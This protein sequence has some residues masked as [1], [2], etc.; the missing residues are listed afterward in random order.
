MNF[1]K[2]MI[3]V[4]GLMLTL[5]VFLAGC[6]SNPSAN[7]S[8]SNN[9]S[10]PSA[11]TKKEDSK[12]L[13]V[14]SNSLSDGRGDW[15]KEKA[16]AQ[17]FKLEFV[18]AGGGD[19]A[20]R[21]IAEKNNP[22]ADVVFGLSTVDY[23]GFKT[24]G[25]LEKFKPTWSDE[26]TAGLNDKED[27]YHSLVKQ[28]ILLIYNSKLYD[29]NTAPK[30][31]TDLW[32][33]SEF[34]NKYDAPSA[35]GGGTIRAVLAGI[36]VRYQDPNGEYGISKAGWDEIKNYLKNGYHA[37]QG[38]DFYANLA[39]GKSP[40]GPMWSSGIATREEKYG[41]KAGIVKPSIGVPFV[42]EQI[43]IVKGSKNLEAA[44]QFVNWFGSAE[45]QSEWSKKFTTMPANEK[46][47]ATASKDIKDLEAS[48]KVQNIDWAFVAKNMNKWV[49]KIQLELLP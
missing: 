9:P 7:T 18:E 45:V 31:W 36:L 4:T 16:A 11:I 33:K 23:E 26:I 40:L 37:A 3:T 49:E 44:K 20:N 8:S 22:V 28:A 19:I 29:E 10:T 25:L 12:S 6:G 41:V 32:K 15:L 42:V 13:V 24:Q 27:Y 48:L 21:L 1:R 17:G 34:Q 2:S 47:L 38:E 46:A 14:Y 43:A 39:S 35:F 5:T 30:D